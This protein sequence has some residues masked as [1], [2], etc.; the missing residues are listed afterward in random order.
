[1]KIRL[2]HVQW[3][4]EHPV[5]DARGNPAYPGC[6]GMA[7]Y[8]VTGETEHPLYANQPFA[9]GSDRAIQE[10]GHPRNVWGW[11]GNREAPSLTPS[12]ECA[13]AGTTVR[14]HIYL[15]AGKIVPCDSGVEAV[16]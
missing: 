3:F 2:L 9:R 6:D 8:E 11:D 16:E 12:F 5:E 10:D 13:W 14:I 1:M 7:V 15:T 4:D